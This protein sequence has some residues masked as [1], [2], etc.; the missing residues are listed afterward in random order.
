MDLQSMACGNCGA[1]LQMPA[2]VK[3]VTCNYCHS[4]LAVHRGESASYTEKIAELDARTE[5]MAE[6]VAR[7]RYESELARIDREWE[8]ESQNYFG[9]T[10][11]GEL[12]DNNGYIGAFGAVAAVCGMCWTIRAWLVGSGTWSLGV[13]G[14][15]IGIGLA[16]FAGSLSG[17]LDEARR[18]YHERRRELDEAFRSRGTGATAK[19]PTW[20]AVDAAEAAA[21]QPK[22]PADAELTA[23]LENAEKRAQG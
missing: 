9:E 21:E 8:R 12:V 2:G 10:Q 6:D 23:F 14:M 20:P 3:F 19:V 15:A 4:S 18:R 13:L 16:V 22:T 11:R 5:T 17:E 7:L 1:P